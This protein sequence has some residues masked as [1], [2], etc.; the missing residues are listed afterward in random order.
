MLADFGESED[1]VRAADE[2]IIRYLAAHPEAQ[3]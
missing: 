3:G 1:L 2:E